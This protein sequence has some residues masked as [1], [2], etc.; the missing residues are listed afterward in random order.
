MDVH[1]LQTEVEQ[2]TAALAS[3]CGFR[4]V[5][6]GP[7][8]ELVHSEP[9]DEL[10]RE[11]YRLL[12]TLMRPDRD[13]VTAALIAGQPMRPRVEL[14]WECDAAPAELVPAHA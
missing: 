7:N 13:T 11:G 9:D 4:S 3:F 8:G 5:W 14:G 2:L 10:E 1:T 12:A 6:R